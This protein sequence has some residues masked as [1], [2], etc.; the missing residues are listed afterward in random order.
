MTLPKIINLRL[1]KAALDAVPIFSGRKAYI[2]NH[3]CLICQAIHR[4]FIDVESVSVGP[5]QATIDGEKFHYNSYRHELRIE[6]AH[7]HPDKFKPF[8]IRLTRE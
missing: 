5:G 2:D 4:R 1:T 8:S 3:Q 7:K 6:D